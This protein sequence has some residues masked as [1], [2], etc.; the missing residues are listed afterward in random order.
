V[1][2]ITYPLLFAMGLALIGYFVGQAR[3]KS[4]VAGDIKK[5]ASL[6][7]QHALNVA[8]STLLPPFAFVALIA[9]LTKINVFTLHPTVRSGAA[10]NLRRLPRPER[11]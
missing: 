9:L 1:L 2:P 8:L 6:P 7:K 5:L 10:E 11:V 4:V 3:A